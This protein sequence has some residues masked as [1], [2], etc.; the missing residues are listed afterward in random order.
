MAWTLYLSLL[1]ER[2]IRRLEQLIAEPDL[3]ALCLPATVL[4]C[5]VMLRQACG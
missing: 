3:D 1:A 5:C 4:A 2:C